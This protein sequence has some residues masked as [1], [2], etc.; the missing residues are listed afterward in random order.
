MSLAINYAKM[1]KSKFHNKNYSKPR[2]LIARTTTAQ[3]FNM[4]K[5]TITQL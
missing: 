3:K 5:L 1:S 2:A 4:I